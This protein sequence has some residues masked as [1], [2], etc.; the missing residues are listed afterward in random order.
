MLTRS[1]ARRS[2]LASLDCDALRSVLC[3][4]SPVDV[5]RFGLT[6]KA[7]CTE[8]RAEL[9]QRKAAARRVVQASVT[10]LLRAQDQHIA[11]L[12]ERSKLMRK[13]W[14]E[15]E[16][17]EGVVDIFDSDGYSEIRERD[18]AFQ[19]ERSSFETKLAEARTSL[20]LLEAEIRTALEK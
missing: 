8:A 2:Q 9:N 6:S 18:E 7:H 3:V 13:M 12:M 20:Q 19:K 17:Q 4:S 15:W 14:E 10:T 1:K 16:A 5:L 11:W